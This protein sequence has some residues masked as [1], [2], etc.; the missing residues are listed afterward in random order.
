MVPISSLEFQSGLTQRFSER[1]GMYFLSDQVT[2]CDRKK[3]TMELPV[4]YEMRVKDEVS[5]IQWLYH[6][7]KTKPQTTQDITPQFMQEIN[8]WS[9]TEKPLELFTLLDQNFLCYNGKEKVPEQ[10]HTYLASNWKDVRNLPK[11]DPT[12]IAK[13]KDRWYVPDPNKA[14]DLEK[15]RE[16]DLLKEFEG[17][18]TVK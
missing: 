12:L 8:G 10:I 5:A 18:K 9:K 4:N 2:E 17:Y 16:R 3:I 15:L 14:G 7:L 13:A 11:D 6:L 1:D